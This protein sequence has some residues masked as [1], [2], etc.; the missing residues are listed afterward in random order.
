[1]DKHEVKELIQHVLTLE[2]LKNELELLLHNEERI[3][4][5]KKDY[6]ELKDILSRGGN[7]SAKAA[8]SIQQFLSQ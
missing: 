8:A 5:I 6:A 3:T 4:A 7:A 1:M 2:N